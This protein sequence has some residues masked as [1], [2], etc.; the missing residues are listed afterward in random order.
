VRVRWTPDAEQ[1]RDNIRD[2]ILKENPEAALRMDDLF[3]EAAAKLAEFPNLGR[4]GRVPGTRELF[5]HRSY[6]V[7]YQV[8]DD[9]VWILNVVHTAREWPPSVE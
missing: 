9:V 5:P 1:D 8:I 4:R 2:Y 7:V 6:R 3:G